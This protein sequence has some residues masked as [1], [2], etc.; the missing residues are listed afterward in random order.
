M[1]SEL[2]GLEQVQLAT[3]RM[4]GSSVAHDDHSTLPS[5]AHVPEGPLASPGSSAKTASPFEIHTFPWNTI[6][7]YDPKRVPVS[8]DS[9]GTWGLD[10]LVNGPDGPNGKAPYTF[11]ILIRQ[12]ILGSSEQRLTLAGIYEAIE[13]RYPYYKSQGGGWKVRH[14]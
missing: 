12:A 11:A 8:P 2:N 14:C 7:K 5:S 6:A 1:D 3:G 13:T 10:K 9:N 4:D